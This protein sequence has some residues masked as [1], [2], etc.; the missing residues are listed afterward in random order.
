MTKISTHAKGVAISALIFDFDGL[1][2]DTEGALVL[3]ARE[4]FASYSAPFP[5]DRWLTV[6]GTSS[7][8]DFWVP[9][10]VEL[11]DQTIDPKRVLLEFREHN[12]DLVA[13]LAPNP[14]V[15]AMLDHGDVGNLGLA[16]ASSSPTSWVE[17]LAKQL[18]IH[19]RFATIVCREHAPRAKPAPDL[20][21]EAAHRLGVPPN[22]CVAFE[23]SHNGS[24]AAVRAQMHC[25]AVPSETTE[26]QDFGHVTAR[27]SSLAEIRDLEHLHDLIS[28][29]E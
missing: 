21:F 17:P 5:F 27:V 18:G 20:Y 22:R 14:G 15:V 6:I 24:L 4:V 3:S 1:L 12:R 29:T 2:C 7:S 19:E 11:S 13:R 28:I 23:D 16:I 25:V 26:T 10:L 9:W 8:E